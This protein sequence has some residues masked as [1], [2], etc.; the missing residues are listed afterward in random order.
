[1]KMTTGQFADK[2]RIWVGDSGKKIPN[3]FIITALNWAFNSLPNVP[4]LDRAFSKHYTKQL[5]AKG[6]YRWNLNGDFRRLSDIRHLQFYTSKGGDPCPLTIC[7]KDNVEFYEKN[8]LVGAKKAGTPCEY[9]LEIEGDDVWLVLD[10]PSNVPII[11]DYIALGYPKPV[12]S[13]EDEIDLSAVI[14]NLVMQTMREVYY[15]ESEDLAFA[16]AA[17]DTNSNKYIPEAIQK[18]NRRFSNMPPVIL[19]EK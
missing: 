12:T 19:G 13:M 4:R 18:L 9:T 11:V 14:E 7:P 8:G 17:L 5:N 15:Y 6:H 16:G 3:E 1:M 2:F 10:R